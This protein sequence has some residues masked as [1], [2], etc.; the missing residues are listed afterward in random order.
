LVMTEAAFNAFFEMPV[1][2][3]PEDVVA[4]TTHL[5][6]GYKLRRVARRVKMKRKWKVEE[7][8]F[9]LPE[10]LGA[11]LAEFVRMSA[12]R[13][14]YKTLNALFSSVT[15]HTKNDLFPRKK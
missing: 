6:H 5:I 10:G 9:V 11:E 12:S 8:W 7:R 4:D 2:D 13:T 15:Y 14:G 1:T 3:L